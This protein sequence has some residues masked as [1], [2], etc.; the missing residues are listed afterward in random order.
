MGFPDKQSEASFTRQVIQYARLFGWKVVHV[1]PLRTKTGW[2]TPVSGDGVGLP[3]T[4]LFRPADGRR[5]A[6]ELKVGSNK[7]TPAQRQWLAD[8]AA[9]G[10]ETFLWTP[11]DW[12]EIES[13]LGE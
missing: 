9:C 4:L 1:R 6:A 12:G 13:T 5:V 2:K 10:F 3:D 7:P 11:A 8:L